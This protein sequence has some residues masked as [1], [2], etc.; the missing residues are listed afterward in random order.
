MSSPFIFLFAL[1]CWFKYKVSYLPFTLYEICLLALWVWLYHIHI[2]HHFAHFVDVLN[3]SLVATVVIRIPFQSPIFLIISN[4]LLNSSLCVFTFFQLRP[5]EFFHQN[6][7]KSKPSLTLLLTVCLSWLSVKLFL[8]NTLL[9][10]ILTK[11][12]SIDSLEIWLI[13]HLDFS[14]NY[15]AGKLNYFFQTIIYFHSTTI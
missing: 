7:W 6:R 5:T 2:L 11:V 9:L 10:Y 8:I 15:F 4:G 13:L 3:S 1:F 12:S 14:G